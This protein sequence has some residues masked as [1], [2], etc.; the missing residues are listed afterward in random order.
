MRSHLLTTRRLLLA[1]EDGFAPEPAWSP[2]SYRREA[3][4]K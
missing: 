1:Q 4:K 3:R 2:S